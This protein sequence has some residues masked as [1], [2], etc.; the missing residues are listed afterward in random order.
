M[1]RLVANVHAGGGWWGPDYGVT[2]PPPE[3]AAEITN[4]AAWADDDDVDAADGAEPDD[5]SSLDREKV[6]AAL[7]G[8]PDPDAVPDG[9]IE[10]VVAWVGDDPDRARRA[11]DTE[12]ATS[13]PRVTLVEHLEVIAAGGAEQ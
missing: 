13:R 6:A 5:S 3:V 10:D 7:V 12:N 1:S 8:T 4:P 11:L 9:R 2:E